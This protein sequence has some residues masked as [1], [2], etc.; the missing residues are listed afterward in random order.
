M[1]A[2]EIFRSENNDNMTQS[3]VERSVSSD[4]RKIISDGMSGIYQVI[5]DMS[6]KQYGQEKFSLKFTDP[7]L[8]KAFS[9][10]YVKYI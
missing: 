3:S 8:E 7:K 5:S 2:Q 1:E 6:E 9:K 4:D 10:E